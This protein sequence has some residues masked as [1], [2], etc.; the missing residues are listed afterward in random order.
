M[1][2]NEY[3]FVLIKKRTK[4]ILTGREVSAVCS[5]LIICRTRQKGSLCQ[6]WMF[7]IENSTHR[8][9]VLSCFL[10][11]EVYSFSKIR[12]VKIHYLFLFQY[13]NLKILRLQGITRDLK[14]SGK[15]L[16]FLKII[17]TVEQRSEQITII[18][19]ITQTGV[20]F[21]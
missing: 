14:V 12:K 19:S 16:T 9:L 18:N 4:Q 15:S 3:S 17:I 2:Q 21:I 13:P 8:W 1:N 7:S 5:I 11:V 10:S 6:K 20:L